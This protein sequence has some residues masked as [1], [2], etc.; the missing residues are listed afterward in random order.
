MTVF[1]RRLAPLVVVLALTAPAADAVP[2]FNV[3][4]ILNGTALT[5]SFDFPES[6][7]SPCQTFLRWELRDRVMLVP[8]GSQPAVPLWGIT[9]TTPIYTYNRCRAP[10]RLVGQPFATVSPKRPGIVHVNGARNRLRVPWTPFA[11]VCV[12]GTRLSANGV[13]SGVTCV[14]AVDTTPPM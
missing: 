6:P 8:I 14:A 4:A 2:M 7:R 3:K 13:S 9:F 11:Q 10:R 12:R 5:L 1:L